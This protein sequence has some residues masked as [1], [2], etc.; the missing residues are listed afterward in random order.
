[1]DRGQ[2]IRGKAGR[3]PGEAPF[4]CSSMLSASLSSPL[5]LLRMEEA[6]GAAGASGAILDYIQPQI[7]G[8]F[9]WGHVLLT[10]RWVVVSP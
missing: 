6:C 4:C 8:Q 7:P 9:F 1:M 2:H 5:C 3:F 10:L